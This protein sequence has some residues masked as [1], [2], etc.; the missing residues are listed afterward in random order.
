[1][2]MIFS[3]VGWTHFHKIT[4]TNLKRVFHYWGLFVTLKGMQLLINK[5]Y[6]LIKKYNFKKSPKDI[7]SLNLP[8]KHIY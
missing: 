4:P 8:K 7:K 5:P 2:K 1:M 6:T 3:R